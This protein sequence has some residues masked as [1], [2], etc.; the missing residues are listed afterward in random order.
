MRGRSSGT[1]GLDDSNIV[2]LC[3]RSQR[4]KSQEAVDKCIPA[5]KSVAAS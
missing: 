3:V 2:P 4:Q 1:R 5:V